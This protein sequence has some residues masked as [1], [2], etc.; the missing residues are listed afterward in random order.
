MFPRTSDQWKADKGWNEF[1][2]FSLQNIRRQHSGASWHTVTL[3]S[4][5]Y[6]NKTFT[7]HGPRGNYFNMQIA[8]KL[9]KSY[10]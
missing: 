2:K 3:T 1:A 8:V 9:S 6:E 5:E 4:Y 7:R 10:W